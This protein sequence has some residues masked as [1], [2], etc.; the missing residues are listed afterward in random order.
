MSKASDFYA[1]TYTNA[2]RIKAMSDLE[3]AEFLT[4]ITND[5]QSDSIT[6]CNYMWNE[7]LQEEVED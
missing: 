4:R 7:W 2:D 3:L 5:A 1:D 6:K